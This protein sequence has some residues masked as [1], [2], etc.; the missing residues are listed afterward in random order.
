[1]RW[2]R[3][4]RQPILVSLFR[5]ARSRLFD[6]TFG[7]GPHVFP[8]TLLLPANTYDAERNIM[9]CVLGLTCCLLGLVGCGPRVVSTVGVHS[10]P[11]YFSTDLICTNNVGEQLVDVDLYVTAYFERG[12][13]TGQGHFRKWLT[14]ETKTISVSSAGGTLQRILL[15]GKARTAVQEE[16]ISIHLEAAMVPTGQAP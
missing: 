12:T 8:N 13:S 14:K 2:S 9:R 7:P 3:S 10:D 11:G 16:V 15:T 4:D 5:V 6:R 1:M